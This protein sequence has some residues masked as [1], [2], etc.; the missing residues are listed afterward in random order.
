[1]FYYYLKLHWSKTIDDDE[2]D[3]IAFY[4]YLKLHWSK[5]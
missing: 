2:S 4:Y 1:M 3:E 5:T